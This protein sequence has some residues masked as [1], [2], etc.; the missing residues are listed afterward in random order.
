MKG[1]GNWIRSDT[2]TEFFILHYLQYDETG[3]YVNILRN[4]K[5]RRRNK[6]LLSGT[7]GEWYTTPSGPLYL[8]CIQSWSS[9]VVDD[10]YTYVFGNLFRSGV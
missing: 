5:D 3:G 9:C 7:V 4:T 10:L 2:K 8:I 6:T 1:K